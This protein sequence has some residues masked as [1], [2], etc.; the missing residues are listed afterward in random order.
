[1]A[2]RLRRLRRAA[3]KSDRSVGVQ[4]GAPDL[5]RVGARRHGTAQQA[6]EAVTHQHRAQPIRRLELHRQ[7]DVLH[8]L[9]Q[10]AEA[11]LPLGGE[12]GREAAR[13]HVGGDAVDEAPARRVAARAAAQRDPARHAVEAHQTMLQVGRLALR[14]GGEVLAPGG[15]VVRVH[16]GVPRGRQRLAL[17]AAA[18]QAL[19]PRP[20]EDGVAAAVVE[21]LLRE[22]DLRHGGEH[23]LQSPARLLELG[24]GAALGRHVDDDAG[25][26]DAAVAAG[27]GRR[28]VEH[29]AL[30]AVEADQ[31][32]RDVGRL[33]GAQPLA[34]GQE[35]GRVRR[36]HRR[37]PGLGQQ[38]GVLADVGAEHAR[39]AGARRHEARGAIGR[40]LQ[41]VQRLVGLRQLDAVV[42]LAD[43]ER[44]AVDEHATAGGR[45]RLHAVE[46]L[47]HD[48]VEADQPVLRLHRLAAGQRGV[49]LEHGLAIVGMDGVPPG[50]VRVLAGRPARPAGRRARGRR[51]SRGTTRR[52][53]APPRTRA[54]RA[55]VR[56][57]RAPPARRRAAPAR[58]APRAGADASSPARYRQIAGPG[59]IRRRPVSA[60]MSACER[61]SDEHRLRPRL[62]RA[63]RR[64]GPGPHRS[65]RRGGG[66]AR[67]LRPARRPSASTSTTRRCA[68]RRAASPACTASC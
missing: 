57:A 37:G 60:I 25:R 33:A 30:L 12:V 44:D 31:P 42:R 51:T 53:A 7:H 19:Q 36:V 58:R 32:V 20:D 26:Q 68:T 45:A 40:E 14:D 52:P 39:P 2:T 29:D 55:A 27:R 56:C 22:H 65:D 9:H 64:A 63:R 66:R 41:D 21:Q 47:P 23:R 67:R 50:R 13:G 8:R 10:R 1:M 11:V 49:H 5:D 3:S 4:G 48:A 34:R 28:A 16:G 18:E 43:V 54:R 24:A 35:G 6:L 61:F 59:V 62:G 17:E 15:P 38:V 46:D